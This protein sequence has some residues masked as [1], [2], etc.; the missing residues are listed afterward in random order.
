MRYSSS[1]LRRELT[2]GARQPV[3][4]GRPP[5]RHNGRARSLLLLKDCLQRRERRPAATSGLGSRARGR[6]DLV[7]FLDLEPREAE[8]RGGFGGE[9]YERRELQRNVRRL[10]HTLAELEPRV[11]DEGS[12]EEA[13]D[14]IVVDAGGSTEEVARKIREVVMSRLGGLWRD[15]GISGKVRRV[16]R[17]KGLPEWSRRMQ[18][19][20]RSP[21]S[22]LRKLSL[23]LSF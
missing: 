7:V 3:H 12:M 22:C 11:V 15:G 16:G 20:W 1:F 6:P 17:W 21:P 23:V 18:P 4:R 14:M 9:K 19:D 2:P 10:F 13:E 5:L 8:Q